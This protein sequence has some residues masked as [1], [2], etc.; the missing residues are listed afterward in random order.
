MRVTKPTPRSA[1]ITLGR[2]EKAL[3]QTATA[4]GREVDAARRTVIAKARPLLEDG[5]RVTVVAP[6]E[7]G[8]W[9]AEEWAPGDL[10]TETV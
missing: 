5:R 1:R 10:G 6:M 3:W 8:G 4:D 2:G 9:T 7:A